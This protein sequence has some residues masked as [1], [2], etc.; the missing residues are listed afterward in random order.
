M[1]AL[2]FL[3]FIIVPIAEIAIFIE[4]GGAI[5]LWNT[6]G[7]IVLTAIAGTALLRAQGL[8]TLRRA[9]ESFARHVFPV[10]E[11]FDGLCL[12]VA[13]ALLLTPGFATDAAGLALFVPPIRAALRHAMLRYLSAAGGARIWVDGEETGGPGDSARHDP[14]IIEGEFRNIDGDD[15]SG[16]NS[17]GNG[18]SGGGP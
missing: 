7:L 18:R 14:R 10:N 4:V 2:I 11:L 3:A 16:G 8:S 15:D 1:A 5:G 6:V 9:Q 12:L 17:G 13:G